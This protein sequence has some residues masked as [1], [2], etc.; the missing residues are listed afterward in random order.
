MKYRFLFFHLSVKTIPVDVYI[1]AYAG[2]LLKKGEIEVPEW[3]EDVKTAVRKQMPPQDK[4]WFYTR[5]ASVARQ[6]YINPKGVGVGTLA[7]FYGGRTRS[8][9]TK[10]FP[11]IISRNHKISFERTSKSRI[12]RNGRT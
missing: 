5:C 11:T 2:H 4:D 6:L 12:Y 10:T 9:V 8:H 1:S 3:S 7:R